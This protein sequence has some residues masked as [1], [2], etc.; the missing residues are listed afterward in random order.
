MLNATT[1]MLEPLSGDEIDE[2]IEH[3]AGDAPLA[4]ALRERVR[5]AAE[6]NPLFVEEMIALLRDAPGGDVSV[7]AT[8]G[9]LLTARIDQ[10]DPAERAVLQRGAVEGRV[11][12]R[13]AVQALA[14]E[15]TRV[16]SRLT[17]L[18]RKELIRP[19]R[20][21]LEGDD[22][23][24]FRH[25][26]I[27]DAAYET[28]PK[29]TRAELHER[30]ADWL[31]RHERRLVEVD[32][33]LG[34][35]LE[36]AYRYRLE[37]RQLDEHG[38]QLAARASDLL[39]GAGA[40]ALGRN[41]VGAALKLLRRA[42]ALHPARD[43]AVALRIDLSEALLFSGDFAAAE[44][45]TKEAAERALDAE[46]ECGALR[47][48]LMTLRIS[49][50]TPKDGAGDAPSDELLTLAEQALPIFESAGDD[51][52]LT[53]AYL[54]IAW[55]QLIRC[56]WGVMLEALDGALGHARRAGYAR[57]ERE[58]PG[59]KS[60]ALFHGATP[61][62]EV[63]AWHEEQQ[64]RHP[65]ALG[66]RAVL[67]AMRG[68]FEEA[69]VLTAAGEASAE[70]LGQTFLLAV[71]GMFAWEV[72][73]LA[74]E[75]SAAEAIARRMCELLEQL[76][77][78]G[79]RSLASGQLAESLYEL[80]RLDEA[81]R[82]TET[83]EELSTNDDVV[84]Q[85]VWRQVRAKVLARQGAHDAAAQHARDAVSLGEQTD[86]L[87]GRGSALA[88]LAEVLA[89]AGQRADAAVEL[90]RAIVLYERKGNVVSAEKLRV[91]LEKLRGVGLTAELG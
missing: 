4:E 73:T 46:D 78:T 51:A 74:G 3:L 80:G 7:P 23:F 32:E 5:D 30:F 85:M 55:A 24:R 45:I 77:D 36:R 22:G 60:T 53:E 67:E 11:F 10:L 64:S 56:R 14:P 38:E 87:N 42:L 41:D 59:W 70:E 50:Q 57:W 47:A 86:M 26:L 52:A 48:R 25:I 68:S 16:G 84:S 61:V 63:L 65:V 54:A 27:R 62:D 2:L 12:H 9:A 90:D 58:L 88:D 13:G 81:R 89:L 76:G 18:V 35:H 49:S 40:R 17:A 1:I 91:R 43:P 39:A 15:E 69:R 83:A 29:A 6:G 82:W 31:S 21:Q 28:L 75:P 71:G 20:P 79:M 8:I 44:E 34:Y 66:H 72:E 33:I 37:L 19:D